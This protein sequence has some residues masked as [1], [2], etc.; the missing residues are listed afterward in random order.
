MRGGRAVLH[1]PHVATEPSYD[2]ILLVSF[3]GPEKREEVMPFLENV[4]RGKNVPKAR[5]LEV[6]E[7]YYALDGKSPINGHNRALIEA[8]RHELDAHGIELPIYWGNRNWHPLL[9]DTVAEMKAKGVRRALAITTSAYSSYSGCRQYL[10]DIEAAREAAG[11][12]A[13]V[14]DKVRVFFNH[15][16]WIET[17]VE[18]VE[19]ALAQLPEPR[20]QTA[21]IAFTAHSLPLSMAEHCKYTEQ[22][23]ETCRLVAGELGRRDWQLVYQSRSGPAQVP[24]LGPDIVEHLEALSAIGVEDLIVVPIGF[25]CDHMEVVFDLD[26]ELMTAAEELGMNVVRAATPGT[27][28]KFVAMLRELVEERLGKTDR[29]RALGSMGPS[30]D[31]CPPDCCLY[32]ARR[33]RNDTPTT[34]THRVPDPMKDTVPDS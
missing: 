34:A 10:E 11:D 12:G 15:P 23:E 5:L 4:V 6:A 7:H 22:L 14:I 20:R 31:V 2:A 24:W 28:P 27:H 16:L 25:V 21:R 1:P 17:W 13:P 19:E 30:H 32:P 33:K 18:R 29:R 26:T 9:T 3:G 8:L